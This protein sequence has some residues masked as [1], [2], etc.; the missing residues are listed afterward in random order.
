MTNEE[1]SGDKEE[2]IINEDKNNIE[3]KS[4]KLKMVFNEE[5][6]IKKTRK[7]ITFIRKKIKANKKRTSKG[8]KKN[9][10]KLKSI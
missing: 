9:I 1:A 2:Q 6:L 8:K 5:E 4:L 7:E 10:I 3:K